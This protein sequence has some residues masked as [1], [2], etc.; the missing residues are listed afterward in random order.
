MIFPAHKWEVHQKKPPVCRERG[1]T[2]STYLYFIIHKLNRE[3]F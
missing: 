3:I 2:N 1:V